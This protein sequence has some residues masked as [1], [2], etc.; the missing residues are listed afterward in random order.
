MARIKIEDLPNDMKI[1][2]DDMRKITGGAYIGDSSYSLTTI[3]DDV[4]LDLQNA[5]QQQN[6]QFTLMS[7]I[8]NQLH[9][10]AMTIVRNLRP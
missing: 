4:E 2:K 8:S 10:T 9:D 5:M 7:Q 1:S 6:R 3:S